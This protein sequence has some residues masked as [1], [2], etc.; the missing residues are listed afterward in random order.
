M[1]QNNKK[2][3]KTRRKENRNK[4]TF[5]KNLKCVGVNAA[6]LAS[7]LLSLDVMLRELQPS[8]FMIQ[9]TKLYRQGKI[10]T[11]QAEKF[12]IY[13]LNRKNSRGGGLCIGALHSLDPVWIAEGDDDSEFLVVGVTLGQFSVR[14]ICGYG[15]QLNDPLERKQKFWADME[16]QVR[17]ADLNNA[18]VIIQMDSNAWLG[19]SVIK[20]DPNS[21]NKNGELLME[22]IN[23]NQNMNIINGSNICNGTITRQ[24]KTK[25]K[26]EESILDLFIVCDKLKP[27][28]SEMIID[29]ER[30]HPL[31]TKA[32]TFSDH[33]TTIL[34]MSISVKQNN[35]ERRELFNFRNVEC[36]E[37]FRK[38]TEN[39]KKLTDCFKTDEPL[40]TQ[41][42]KWRKNLEKTFHQSFRKI[43]VKEPKVSEENILLAQKLKLINEQ[44]KKVEPDPDLENKVEEIEKKLSEL[45]SKKNRDKVIK[46]FKT[47]SGSQGDSF[48]QGV[49]TIKKK[50][51][52]KH[53][54]ALPVAVK[55]VNGRLM[56]SK[57]DIKKIYLE[58]F[59]FRLRD[60]PIKEE[61]KNIKEITE[62]LCQ[63]RLSVTKNNKSENWTMGDLEKTL[64]QLKK[65]KSRD[66]E[67]LANE[68]FRP[69]VAGNDLKESLLTMFNKMKESTFIPE[70]MRLKN[71]TALYK[72][73]GEMNNLANSRGIIVG[74][75]FNSI[76]MSLIYN[77][78][79]DVIDE[80]M[81]D[82][83]A[84]ARRGKNIRLHNWVLNSVINE[85][86]KNKL[87]LDVIVCDYAEAFDSLW[88]DSICNDLYD[89]GVQ[90]DQL[91]LIYEADRASLVG[92]KSPS[93][94]TD[95]EWVQ[96]KVLQGEKL[97][98]IKC[99]NSVDKI[100]KYCL[101]NK[102]Y[103]H[104][105]RN[106]VPVPPLSLL[107]DIIAIAKC[108]YKSV[109]MASYLNT[110]TNIRKL[111]FGVKKCFKLHVGKDHIKCPELTIDNWKL[112]KKEEI[113]SNIWELEDIEDKE[114]LINEVDSTRYLGEVVCSSG[115]QD[116]NIQARVQRGM[117]AANTIIQILQETC[118]GKYDCEVFLVLRDSLLLSTLITNSE[119]WNHVT[120]KNIELLEAV[121]EKMLRKKF[122]LHPKTSKVYLYLELS[123]IP[124][125][126]LIMQRRVLFLKFLLNEDESSLVFQI[127][128]EQLNNELKHDWTETVRQDLAYLDIDLSME[129]IKD[130]SEEDFKN[131]VREKTKMKAFEYLLNIKESQSKMNKLRYK[132]FEIQGYLKSTQNITNSQVNFTLSA[133]N[134]GLNLRANFKSTQ[135]SL[136]CRG[137][138]DKNT[139]ESQ[140]HLLTCGA[141]NTNSVSN[142]KEVKYDDLFSEDPDLIIK[143][144]DTLRTLY[145]RFQT[146]LNSSPSACGNTRAAE[147]SSS[148]IC[149]VS[150]TV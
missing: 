41:C 76:L 12:A 72:G 21:Q 147:T 51:F 134:R 77:G 37:I 110:Q 47:L 124:I 27:Y 149:D 105:Y 23:R 55:N 8:I 65:N 90:D 68:L 150:D 31:V 111:R 102:T 89:S 121:D 118:F 106:K 25:L 93:G 10:K 3:N 123:L 61:Y 130:T 97:G 84:G 38:I 11:D 146:L 92:V 43:R 88:V 148:S 80:N 39:N 95:R 144:S 35:E 96:K 86:I 115:S 52:P 33:F 49:W 22:F 60:R 108:G 45:T 142:N 66:P 132:N 114:A 128:Q 4:K 17:D 87:E 78:K 32:N 94:M 48:T 30:R 139:I 104:L 26:T 16:A 117:S 143:A 107:D 119:T 53:K 113:I 127:L 91:N 85:A 99:G 59:S 83:Q 79:Y 44:K 73:S 9:E 138:M 131:E 74:S 122:E 140:E 135:E 57:S 70:F 2:K 136:E 103:L 69:D 56:T 137:C 14:A 120:K 18:G 125:R 82:S 62:E 54:A 63:L 58:T 126:F 75:V 50:I 40:E 67:G 13:E 28:V 1:K 6:G 100:G 101:E 36:Q 98:P 71:I 112:E 81:S 133:R 34:N 145:R 19:D 5:N 20:G 46:N 29:E 141:L 7:K 109:E 15:P 24:R 42:I 64:K 116:K 129:E